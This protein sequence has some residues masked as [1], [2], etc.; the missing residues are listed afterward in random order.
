MA[1]IEGFASLFFN[2]ILLVFLNTTKQIGKADIYSIQ[3][4]FLI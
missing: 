4:N 2:L 1:N 3:Q